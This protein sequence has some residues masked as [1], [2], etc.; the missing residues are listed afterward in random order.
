[1]KSV[2]SLRIT[3]ATVISVGA[4]FFALAGTAFA[5]GDRIQASTVAQ[6][7]CTNGAV[8]G[9]AVVTGNPSAGMANIPDQLHEC[10]EPLLPEVQL[11]GQGG[12]G[13]PRGRRSGLRGALRRERR[14]ER[15]RERGRRR[16]RG[17]RAAR[18]GTFRVIVHPAGRD[19]RAD[20]AFTVVAV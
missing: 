15:G 13:P 14:P 8:R 16:L 3:P 11:H 20:L 6:Q 4:L 2:R 12:P 19:D 10:R 18:K 5:V 7:R 9:V 17:R 1:M